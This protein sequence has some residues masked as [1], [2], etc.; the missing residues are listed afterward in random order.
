M[1]RLLLVRHG[2]SAHVHR[3]LVDRAGMEQWRTAYDA[4][5]IVADPPPED[6]A[7]LV[8]GAHRVVASD[9]ARAVASAERL[10]AG[11]EVRASPLLREHPLPIPAVP[12]LRAPLGVWGA[13]ISLRWG[14]AIARDRD[15]WPEE[16][17]RARAAA[18]WCVEHCEACGDG[19]PTVAVVTHGAFRRLLGR[20]LVADGWRAEP[21]QGGWA[22]WSVW[23]FVKDR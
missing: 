9:M 4:A 10:A 1:P 14:I 16:L 12:L 3:G 5:G 19:D 17:E 6:V 18:A 22:P 20:A 8:A 21:R 7:R 11:R 23:P 2:R 13:L 15:A